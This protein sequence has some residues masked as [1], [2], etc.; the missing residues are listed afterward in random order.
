MSWTEPS[1]EHAVAHVEVAGRGISVTAETNGSRQTLHF[2]ETKLSADFKPQSA[3]IQSTV[4][5]KDGGEL[6]ADIAV[7]DP[8][9]K[10]QLSG[11]VT[12][13]DVQL[14]QFNPVLA[15]LSPQLSASGTLSAEL[16]PRGTL[17]SQRFTAISSLTLLPH[18]VRPCRLT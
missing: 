3:Q 18:K 12:V 6:K 16:Q 5:L 1:P 14:A 2:K 13:D 15:S 17:Q 4:S 7:A 11:S 10:R 9:T 8:L